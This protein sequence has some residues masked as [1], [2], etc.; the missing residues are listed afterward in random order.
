MGRLDLEEAE[1]MM[2]FDE[3]MLAVIRGHNEMQEGKAEPVFPG[4]PQVPSSS[5]FQNNAGVIFNVAWGRFAHLS[6]IE[7]FGGAIRSNHYHKTDSHFMVVLEGKVHYY[8]R[9]CREDGGTSKDVRVKAFER[10]DI[11][12]TPPRVTHTV[13]FPATSRI[14]ALSYK[15]RT[16][17]EHESDLVREEIGVDV[18]TNKPILRGDR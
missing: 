1:K 7:S 14:L 10:G 5:L 3:Y 18:L 6:L 13:Y 12:F 2:S 11:L 8:W 15:V 16:H 4:D 9:K 17:S